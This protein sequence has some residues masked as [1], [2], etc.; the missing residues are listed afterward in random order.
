MVESSAEHRIFPLPPTT[1]HSLPPQSSQFHCCGVVKIDDI[2]LTNYSERNA[3][4]ISFLTSRLSIQNNR[5]RLF[6]RAS[7]I[8][9]G[10][11][12]D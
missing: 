8:E 5:P 6:S 4:I 9:Q 10:G 3:K 2:A 11:G 7:D 12:D 1:S